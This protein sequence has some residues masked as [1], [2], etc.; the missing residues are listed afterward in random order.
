MHCESAVPSSCAVTSAFLPFF[1]SCSR[2]RIIKARRKDLSTTRIILQVDIHSWV[3]KEEAH[4][5]GAK[6]LHTAEGDG[7][8]ED[9]VT[10]FEDGCSALAYEDTRL[11]SKIYDPTLSHSHFY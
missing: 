9:A 1:I 3:C 4:Y 11:R 8:A 10:A 7:E 6:S 5:L 2:S